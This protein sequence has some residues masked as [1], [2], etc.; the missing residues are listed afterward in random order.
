MPFIDFLLAFALIYLTM[1]GVVS[2]LQEFIASFVDLRG[3]YLREGVRSFMHES[4]HGE[5]LVKLFYAHP[6][7]EALSDTRL[8]IWGHRLPSYIP[9]RTFVTALADTL[10]APAGSAQSA[11]E[12]LPQ[13]VGQ[14]PADSKLR[15]QLET[16]IASSGTQAD[17][18]RS[19]LEAHYDAVMERVGGWYKRRTQVVA[20]FIA[21][22]AAAGLNVDSIAIARYL[23]EHPAELARLA[24][25]A[26]L[27]SSNAKPKEGAAAGET[28]ALTPL[29]VKDL[30]AL[31]LPIGWSSDAKDTEAKGTGAER[32]KATASN[33]QGPP[34]S[35]ALTLLGWLITAL[36][37]TLG[38]PFWFD[39]ISK[40][41]PL[42]STGKPPAGEN[43]GAGSPPAAP[44]P[45]QV[46]ADDAQKET[47]ATPDRPLETARNEYE[48]HGLN[49]MDIEAL[50]EALGLPP[51]TCNGVLDQPTRDA[52]K[53]WQTANGRRADGYFD[54]PTVRALLYGQIGGTQS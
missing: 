36:A 39:V 8:S 53:R 41:V 40:L 43:A 14:L 15:R 18:M 52:L 3:K 13:A 2:G 20:L 6:L 46:R 19:V 54:E 23:N 21:L 29:T 24:D 1:A 10:V 27:L 30:E 49:D 34:A 16:L 51:E 44:A 45:S 47:T 9:A 38:A 25:R 48:L 32:G 22:F 7:I 11:L 26:A 12:M 37:A 5:N 31:R 4:A 50:Q 35:G 28:P 33:R 17:A 42:R